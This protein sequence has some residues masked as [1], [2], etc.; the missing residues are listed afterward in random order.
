MFYFGG[1]DFNGDGDIIDVVLVS[2]FSMIEINCYLFNFGLCYDFSDMQIVCVGYSFDYG[3]YCQIGELIIINVY[4]LVIMLFLSMSLLFDVIGTGIGIGIVLQKCDCFLK[5]IFNQG[6]GEY[7]GYF[8]DNKVIFIVGVC[9]LFFKCDLINYCFIISVI[10]VVICFG[11]NIVID[12]I[13]V[14]VY[15]IYQVL[16]NCNFIYSW[17]L[18]SVGFVLQIVV[19]LLLFGNYLKGMQVLGIDNFYNSFY[20][21]LGMVGV[22]GVSFEMIDNFDFGLCYQQGCL[23]VQVFG[24]YIVFY[25]C[26]V[27]FYD[28]EINMM[29]YCN[30]GMVYKYGVDGSVSYCLV[31]QLILYVFGLYLKLKIF[32]DVQVFVMIIYLIVGKCEVGVLSYIFGGCVEGNVGLVCFGLEVKCIGVWYVNDQNLL[33]M[34]GGIQ[35]YGVKVLVYMVVNLDV[36]VLFKLFGLNDQ[37][38]LQLNV[39]NLFDIFYVGGFSGISVMNVLIYVQIGVLCVVFGIISMGF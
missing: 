4:G 29:I 6:F 36:C 9:V 1:V 39:I 30:F 22:K 23:Q 20:Y 11:Q 35:V 26:F 21:V 17:V 16:Q 8:F 34:I 5:V 7:C 12:V 25:D 28:F 24:W 27:L 32:D 13:I 33:V 31:D 37:I 14:V 18:F 3:W 15:L 19:L 38:F 2:V 10:G